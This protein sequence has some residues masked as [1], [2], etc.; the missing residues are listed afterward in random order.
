VKPMVRPF[1]QVHRHD[2]L[3]DPVGDRRDGGIKLRL[4]Q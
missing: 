2:R 3:R 1:L 4:L